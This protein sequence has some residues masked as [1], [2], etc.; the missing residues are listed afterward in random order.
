M[1][2]VDFNLKKTI[3]GMKSLGVPHVKNIQGRVFLL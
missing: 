1:G 2:I 3:V